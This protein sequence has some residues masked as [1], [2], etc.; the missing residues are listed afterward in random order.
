MITK[1]QSIEAYPDKEIA[2][3]PV[4]ICEVCG[5]CNYKGHTTKDC[6]GK[7]QH[8]QRYGHKS[9]LCR[10]KKT[11]EEIEIAKRAK[12]DKIRKIKERRTRGRKQREQWN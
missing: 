2:V 12:E 1:L 3:K 6:W 10:N 11:D 5:T 4:I 8:C 7:C 9:H